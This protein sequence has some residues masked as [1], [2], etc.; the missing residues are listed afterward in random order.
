MRELKGSRKLDK[1]LVNQ[2]QELEEYWS[3][4]AVRITVGQV[5][6]VG[7]PVTKGKPFLLNQHSETLPYKNSYT[8]AQSTLS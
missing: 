1:E 8:R 6:S 2:I 3:E 4:P 5:A 7:E